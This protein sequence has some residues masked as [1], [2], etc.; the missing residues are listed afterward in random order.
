M[1]YE[2]FSSVYDSLTENVSYAQI[3]DKIC[4]LCAENGI[5]GG[6]LLDLG[7]GTGNLSFLLEKRGFDVIGVDASGDMLSVAYEKKSENGSSALFLNQRAQELDLYGTINC[8]VCCLDTVN[9][10]G[11]SAEIKKAFERVSLFL[12]P[13]GVFILDFN[14]EFKHREILKDNTFVYDIDGV[15]CVWQN[16][17]DS[18]KNRT[19][20][21]LDFFLEDEETGL[22]ERQS[23][24]FFEYA[25]S[26]EEITKILKECGLTVKNSFGGWNGEPIGGSTQRIVLIAEKE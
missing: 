6:L 21:D 24:S 7:C 19:Q 2:V 22:Y 5:S 25:C 4:S 8:A 1:S 18:G 15:Y 3:A 9:H 13:K 16:T 11:D 14:T 17:Y 20:V 26:L 10:F 23:E 12:E